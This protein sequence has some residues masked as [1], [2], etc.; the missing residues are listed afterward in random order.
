MGDTTRTVFIS[1]WD[2]RD[3]AHLAALE[4]DACDRGDLM[5][6]LY[7]SEQFEKLENKV[8]GPARIPQ[9]RR[10]STR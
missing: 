6:A 7:W 5:D 2:R 10:A 9:A 1:V 4:R 3:L 8:Y